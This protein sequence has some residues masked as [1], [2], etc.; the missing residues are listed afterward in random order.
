MS[1]ENEQVRG[2]GHDNTELVNSGDEAE[3]DVRGFHGHRG[4]T[5]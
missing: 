5:R 4:T 2:F 3:Y 1:D